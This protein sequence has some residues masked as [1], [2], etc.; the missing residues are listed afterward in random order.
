[1]GNTGGE[2]PVGFLLRGSVRRREKRVAL[3]SQEG[4]GCVE[5]GING[6]GVGPSTRRELVL[7]DV[8]EALG[9]EE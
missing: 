2:G 5:D 1:M 3:E 9:E 7:E 4:G 8:G 6:R